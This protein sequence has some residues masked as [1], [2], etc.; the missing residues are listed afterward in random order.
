MSGE[1]KNKILWA[2]KEVACLQL[3]FTLDTCRNCWAFGFKL[4]SVIVAAILANQLDD[5]ECFKV[6]T[7]H[8][9]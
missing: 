7:A 6:V 3:W 2:G 1:S 4:N 5:F 8:L 9:T